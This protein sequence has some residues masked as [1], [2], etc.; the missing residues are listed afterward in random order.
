MKKLF[1]ILIA[2]SL[3]FTLAAC[4]EETGEEVE[5]MQ[6]RIEDLE[7]ENTTLKTSVHDLESMLANIEESLNEEKVVFTTETD[8]TTEAQT[9]PYTEDGDKTLLELLEFAYDIDYTESDFGAFLNKVGAIEASEGNFIAISKNGEP[10]DVGISEATFTGGDH[11]HFELS[12]FDETLESVNDSLDLFTD[13]QVTDFSENHQVIMG[14]SHIDYSDEEVISELP[15]PGT[16]PSAGT[17]IN[18]IFIEYEAGEAITALQDDLES[19]ASTE[20]VYSAAQAYLALTLDEGEYT[21]FEDDFK[22]ELDGLDVSETDNDTLSMV[23]MALGV[24]EDSDYDTLETSIVDYL[25]TN[26]YNNSYGNNAASFSQMILGLLAVGED[27][28]GDDFVEED[29]HLVEHL[30]VYQNDDGS[31]DYQLDDDSA[32]LQFS[33][34]QAFFALAAYQASLND[35]TFSHPYR[36]GQS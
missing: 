4:S 22:A 13:N 35:E 12:W 2:L 1:S 26:A 19:V 8:T 28:A 33:T 25:K 30:L 10:M 21:Q 6:S 27:P 9:V 11:F 32:D 34:P 3:V 5:S 31:F 18:H 16:D 20:Y 17:L 23:L 7:E 36:L 15:D 14:L 24:M 29:M